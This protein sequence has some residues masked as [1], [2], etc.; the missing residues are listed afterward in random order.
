MLMLLGKSRYFFSKAVLILKESDGSTLLE[1]GV[2]SP[3]LFALT[4]GTIDLGS[5]LFTW[6]LME[7]SLREAARF[8]ITGAEPGGDS[9]RLTHIKSIIDERTLHM[10]TLE[11][12]R[13]EIR[14]YPT[15]QDLDKTEAFDDTGP[16]NGQYDSGEAFTDCN[17]NGSWDTD[18]GRPDSAGGSGQIVVYTLEY[19][20]PLLTPLLSEMISETGKVTLSATVTVRNEPWDPLQTAQDQKSCDR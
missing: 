3:I 5:M 14:S 20:Y 7:S 18:R 10:V 1:F 13:L 16:A 8:G 12:A 2:L 9:N 4:I 15:A 17:G 19:D 11:D 6:T